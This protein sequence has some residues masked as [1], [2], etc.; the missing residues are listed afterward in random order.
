M[1]LAP[2]NLDILIGSV[3]TPDAVRRIEECLLQAPQ[4]DLQTTNV[5]HGRM[6]ARTILVPAGTVLTGALT[7]IDNVCIVQGDISVTTDAGVQRLTGYNV[8]TARAGAK[9]VG[10][11]HA[12]TYWTTIH[13][14]DLTDVEAIEEEMTNEASRL[15]TR[16]LALSRA[17]QP[18]LEVTA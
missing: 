5:V 17:D 14:T 10:Y 8:L 3:P 15:H 1:E 2:L 4:V 13:H 11:A 6:C 18:A 16:T 7:N 9:R 12:D